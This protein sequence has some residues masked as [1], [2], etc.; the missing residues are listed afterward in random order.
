MVSCKGPVAQVINE[1][2]GGIRS[3]MAYLGVDNLEAMAQAALFM[4]VS[5]SCVLE[6]GPHALGS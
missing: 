3:G 1:L 4:E 2:T 5:L 6:N